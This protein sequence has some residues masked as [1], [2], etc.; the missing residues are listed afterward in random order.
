MSKKKIH[1]K[2]ESE[3]RKQSTVR[4]LPSIQFEDFDAADEVFRAHLENGEF[5]PKRP[6]E[7][8]ESEKTKLSKARP[9]KKER[10]RLIDLHGMTVTEAIGHLDRE[11]SLATNA[12]SGPILLKIVTGKGLHS[13]P[14]GGILVTEIYKYVCHRYGPVILSIDS[15][16]AEVALGGIPWRGHFNVTISSL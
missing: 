6:K 16:P 15:S 7:T 8:Y 11:I 2:T 13:G 14:S 10:S 5:L 1:G 9:T 3:R 4:K 12:N